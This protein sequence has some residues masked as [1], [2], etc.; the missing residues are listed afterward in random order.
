VLTLSKEPAGHDRVYYRQR[1]ITEAPL[2]LP[3]GG[4]SAGLLV[5]RLRLPRHHRVTA[6]H[7]RPSAI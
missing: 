2:S 6:Y 1:A 3:P 7:K 5:P 4:Y